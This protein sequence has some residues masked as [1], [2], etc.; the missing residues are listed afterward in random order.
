MPRTRL[1][2]HYAEL[3]LKG[4]NRREFETA[5]QNNLRHRLRAQGLP[6]PVHRGHDRLTVEVPEAAGE[7]QRRS[8]MDCVREVPGVSTVA[9]ALH[10]PQHEIRGGDGAPDPD[11]LCRVMG[12]LAA[13]RWRPG[14]SF[15]VRVNRG[16]K[17]FPLGSEAL[18]RRLGRHIIDR[19]SWQAVNLDH[20]DQTFHIDLYPDG[21]FL[22]ADREAGPGGLPVGTEGHV[23]V[24]LSG[25]IDSPVAAWMVGRRGCSVDF[26]HVTAGHLTPAVASENLVTRIA[27]QLS[28]YTL[29]SRLWLVPYTHLDLAL[30]GQAHEGFAMMLLRRFM[31][32]LG[33]RAAMRCGARALVSGDSL[34]QVASQ[35]LENLVTNSHAT[36]LPVLQPLIGLDKQE[37]V[38]RARQI[39]TFGLST[40]PY[41]DCC[42]LIARHP[43]TR[44]AR[45]Q[46]ESIERRLFPDY[47]GLLERSL[48]DA[49]VIDLD[50]GRISDAEAPCAAA[51]PPARSAP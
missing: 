10:L 50:T 25:G 39:G 18:A 36:S 16:D 47:A 1:L 26:L 45:E 9:D 33:E 15:A 43:R 34:G 2:I 42:A 44:S 51:P 31:A 14:A 5:L 40:Q 30:T 27:L 35:T 6:W 19:T 4:R 12:S 23:L 11:H 48:A 41:K 22:Y 49:V 21:A 38:D 13:A 28:R 20:P 29:R 24:L 3:A 46:V 7:A 17:G 8:A 37:I 32:R